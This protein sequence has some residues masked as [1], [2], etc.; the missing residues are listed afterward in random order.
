MSPQFSAA[1]A[2]ASF[3]IFVA[4]CAVASITSSILRHHETQKTIR[5]AIEKGQALNPET[6]ERILQ[7]GRPPKGPPPRSALLFGGIML[8][9]IAVGLGLIGWSMSLTNPSQLYPG[10]G[11]GGMVG[12][13]GIG[14]LVA[15]LVVGGPRGDGP[16]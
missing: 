3:W 9:A 11:A 10:L 1:V 14:L 6:L 16:K 8:L 7:S 13:L 5:Q 2:A 4:I 15:G 12:M